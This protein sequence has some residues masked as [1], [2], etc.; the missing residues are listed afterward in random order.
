MKLNEGNEIEILQANKRTQ[1][2]TISRL[3]KEAA[4]SLMKIQALRA[5]LYLMN[6]L[7]WKQRLCFL[8]KGSL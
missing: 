4:E 3:K 5:E 6:S 7:N 8:F 2:A 1:D